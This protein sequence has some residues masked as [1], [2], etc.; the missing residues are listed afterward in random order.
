MERTESPVDAEPIGRSDVIDP[1]WFE[2]FARL[3]GTVLCLLREQWDLGAVSQSVLRTFGYTP[4]EWLAAGPYRLVHA[5]D[6]EVLRS[7]NDVLLA[8]PGNT[9][10]GRIRI[11]HRD[12]RWR[13][14]DLFATNL[15]D[16]PEVGGVLVEIRDVTDQV[17]AQAAVR[18]SEQRYRALV[19]H[20][21][22]AIAIIDPATWRYSF[23][24]EAV[25]HV[26]GRSPDEVLALDPFALVH[27]E[28]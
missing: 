21:A 19:S 9:T 8:A 26:M 20:S 6:A 13:W 7:G 11:R 18:A 23:V 25:E 24:S 5:D 3:P 16:D 4:A 1:S 10:S 12:G 28:D 2:R 14:A 15:I 17:Q 27:P 22:D